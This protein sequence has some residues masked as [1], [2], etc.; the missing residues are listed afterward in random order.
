MKIKKTN[1]NNCYLITPKKNFDLRGSFHR[2]YCKK[3]FYKHKINFNIKQTN[4]SI[5]K[6]KYTLRGFHFQKN[7]IKKIKF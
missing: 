1:I 5:N 2:T 4:T 3:I 6:K 7:L